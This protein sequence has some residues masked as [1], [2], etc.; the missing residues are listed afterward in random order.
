M[1]AEVLAPLVE[2]DGGELYFV[3]ADDE[4]VALHVGGTWSGSP[5]VVM[6]TDRI[7]APAVTAVQPGAAVA[8]TYGWSVPEGAERIQPAES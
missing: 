5:A 7:I 6:A 2:S 1:L 8:V 4:N 3:S